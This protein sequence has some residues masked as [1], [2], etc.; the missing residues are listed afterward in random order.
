MNSR[1]IST[2]VKVNIK[3]IVREPAALFMVIL[4]PIMLTTFFG[5]AY[6]GVGGTQTTYQVGVVNLGSSPMGPW[7]QAFVGN[8]TSTKILQVQTYDSNATAQSALQQGKLSAVIIIPASFEQSAEAYRQNPSNPA[9]W[10]VSTVQLYLDSGSMFAV[11]AVHPVVQEALTLSIS[12]AAAQSASLPIEI[13][14]SSL[15]QVA[16]FST[17]D[18]MVPGLFAFSAIFLTMMVA[19]SFTMDREKG[20]L[21]RIN[22]TPTKASEFMASHTLSN[23]LLALLQVGLVFALASAIGYHPQGGAYSLLFAFVLVSVFAVSCVGFGLITATVAKSS[24]AATGIAFIFIMP[25]MFLGTFVSANASGAMATV[26]R[27][28]PSYYV[29]D[30]LTSLFLR[31]ASPTSIA[32]LTDLG[33]VA[34]VSVATLLAG[35]WLYQKYGGS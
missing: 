24:G 6:G 9:E 14:S 15:I 26:G 11:Q 4:F 35:I 16:K 32:V 25:Q 27:F 29:T 8:L 31:G 18:Y 1:R 10:K 5:M 20:L 19:Q 13:G 33:I 12:G 34:G 23:M 17:F 30:A 7:G 21:L 28:V 2:L 3:R 22:T